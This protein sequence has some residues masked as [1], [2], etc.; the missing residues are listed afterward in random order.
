MPGTM[1]ST[2]GKLYKKWQ[3]P[4]LQVAYSLHKVEHEVS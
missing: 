2:M 3:G 4:W 1:L